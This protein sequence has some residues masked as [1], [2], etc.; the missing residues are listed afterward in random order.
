M[1]DMTNAIEEVIKMCL[2]N[3]NGKVQRKDERGDII[4]WLESEWIEY[5]DTHDVIIVYFC[6][7]DTG[8][9]AYSN[10]VRETI[11]DKE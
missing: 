10:I 3:G 2:E 5:D 9:I 8:R 11:T 1:Y 7:S 4:L 6:Y